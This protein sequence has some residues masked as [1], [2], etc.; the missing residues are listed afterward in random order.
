MDS[1]PAEGVPE[2][3]LLQ[4]SGLRYGAGVHWKVYLRSRWAVLLTLITTFHDVKKWMTTRE[5]A[6]TTAGMIFFVVQ[7]L[8]GQH[9]LT[10]AVGF[11]RMSLL[12]VPFTVLMLLMAPLPNL[13]LPFPWLVIWRGVSTWLDLPLLSLV[14]VP[15]VVGLVARSGPREQKNEIQDALFNHPYRPKVDGI[16]Y[17]GIDMTGFPG[18]DGVYVFTKYSMFSAVSGLWLIVNLMWPASEG[19]DTAVWVSLISFLLYVVTTYIYKLQGELRALR[20]KEE[21]KKLW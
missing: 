4:T 11:V 8:L 7:H 18:L 10:Y 17:A 19:G 16:T 1:R 13:V 14:V 2:P 20:G 3:T 9:L 21:K 12:W 15:L 6:G 5:G